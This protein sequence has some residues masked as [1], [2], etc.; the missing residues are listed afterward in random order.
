MNEHREKLFQI[1]EKEGGTFFDVEDMPATKRRRTSPRKRKKTTNKP[2]PPSSDDDFG[3]VD[4]PQT[5]D[6]QDLVIVLGYNLY[7]YFGYNLYIYTFALFY[8]N[9]LLYS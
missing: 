6:N 3:H 7:I 9:V 8:D 2:Q 4:L 5:F 1:Y